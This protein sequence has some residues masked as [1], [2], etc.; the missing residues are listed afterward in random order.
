MFKAE[1]GT[2]LGARGGSVDP[3][4]SC[5]WT[6]V[7]R[8]R[9]ELKDLSQGNGRPSKGPG[10]DEINLAA[11]WKTAWEGTRVKP[12]CPVWVTLQ[13]RERENGKGKQVILRFNLKTEIK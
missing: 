1:A 11:V 6:T 7:K 2:S 9:K 4:P 3:S 12:R 5:G 10:S 8:I 13:Q